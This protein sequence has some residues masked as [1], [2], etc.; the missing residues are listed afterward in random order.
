MTTAQT[1]TPVQLANAEAD[2]AEARQAVLVLAYALRAILFAAAYTAL[3]CDTH[4]QREAWELLGVAAKAGAV[5]VGVDYL[6][7]VVCRIAHAD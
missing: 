3:Y 6:V 2:R 7:R 5:A 4:T 1:M